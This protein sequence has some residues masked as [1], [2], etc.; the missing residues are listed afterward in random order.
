[1]SE[2]RSYY[3]IVRGD[4]NAKKWVV[5]SREMEQQLESMD[6]QKETREGH[7]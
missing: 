4:L 2:D 5:T 6:A 7:D 3:K 1:M